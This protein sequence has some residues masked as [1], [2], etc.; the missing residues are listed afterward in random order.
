MCEKLLTAGS[1]VFKKEIVYKRK[2]HVIG[3]ANEP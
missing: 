1:D 2:Q 3:A